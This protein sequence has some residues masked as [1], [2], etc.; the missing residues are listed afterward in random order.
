[1]RLFRLC[2]LALAAECAHGY[3]DTT[4]FFMFSTSESVSSSF[5]RQ[6]QA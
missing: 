6:A 2:A 5:D 1:M 3:L 4:P